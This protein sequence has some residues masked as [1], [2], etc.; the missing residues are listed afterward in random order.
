MPLPAEGSAQAFHVVTVVW[1]DEFRRLFLDVCVPNQ[2]TPGNLGALPAGSRYRV[3]T[4][5]EDA[6]LLESSPALGQVRELMPVDIVTVRHLSASAKSRFTRMTACHRRALVDAAQVDAAVIFL[7]ADHFLSE[8]AFA[9]VVR[10]RHAGIRAAVCTGIRV[11]RDSFVGA[12]HARG[13]VAGVGA[14]ELVAIALEHLHPSTNALMAHGRFTA[15]RPIGVYWPVPGEGLLARCFNLHPLM[16]DPVRREVLPEDTIDG[17]YV[18]RS[19]PARDQV[20]VLADSDELVVF[21]MSRAS[22]AEVELAPGGVSLWRAATMVGR[23]DSH[24]RWYW[25]QSIRLHA[26]EI[27]EPWRPVEEEAARFAARAARLSDA[28]RWLTLRHWSRIGRRDGAIGKPLRH[29]A[30]AGSKRLR[31]SASVLAHFVSRRVHRLR[32]RAVRA[33]RRGARRARPA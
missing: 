27:G 20:H 25:D 33:G 31:R 11:E 3:F 28:R 6:R 15:R 5:P 8:G 32:K 26:R 9:A 12:L 13:G 22:D 10:R 29:L 18:R 19:C 23:C 17:H 1:G 30:R 16:I 14:R 21:E 4:A 2:L 24:Q 7:C